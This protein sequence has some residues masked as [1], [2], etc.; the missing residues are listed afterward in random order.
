M[1]KK[2]PRFESLLWLFVNTTL[3]VGLLL[4]YLGF[5]GRYYIA[6]TRPSR[7]LG[8]TIVAFLVALFL[9]IRIYGRYDVGRRKSKPIIHSFVFSMFFADIVTY[10][11]HMIMRTNTGIQDFA[12]QHIETLVVVYV[13]QLI[14]VVI[15]T[16]AGNALFFRIHPPERVCIVTN[17][18]ASLDKVASVICKF[19]KQYH[20]EKVIDYRD[21]DLLKKI[22]K[23][24]TVFFYNVPWRY[25]EQLV[26]FCYRNRINIYFNPE[27]ADVVEMS[28]EYY[29][30]DDLSFLNANVKTLTMNQRIMKRLLDI[31]LSLAMLICSS[32]IWLVATIAIK[33]YDGGSVF[34]KQDRMTINGTIFQVYKFRTMKEHVENRSVSE[35]DSR[36]TKPGAILRKTRMDELPQLINILK[37]DMTFVGPRPEMIENIEDYERELPEFR[38]RMKVK[39][40]LTGYAQISGKYNT[41]PK[42]KLIMDLVY[43]E[44]FSIWKDIQLIF[45]TFLVLLKSDSTE[46]FSDKKQTPYVFE[47]YVEDK[48]LK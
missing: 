28:S 32:P 27:I 31:G 2:L 16:Y 46:A 1:R 26:E 20:I 34:F 43:I 33:A 17:S 23:M 44:Q 5:F 10:L 6:L 35:G 45:Q 25:R 36:I 38:Y 13:A 41:S 7:T 30:L 47:K 21:I 19:K 12:F 9:F 11:E 14:L 18:Q 4:M 48:P 42:D 3:Y 22:K 29:V 24:E 15:Y 37:G 8:I 39:A 40:G